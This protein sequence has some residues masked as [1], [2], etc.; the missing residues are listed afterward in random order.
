MIGISPCISIIAVSIVGT[1]VE[2]SRMHL[3]GVKS[4]GQGEEESKLHTLES[5]T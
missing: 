2:I 1:D 5:L 4:N 3:K